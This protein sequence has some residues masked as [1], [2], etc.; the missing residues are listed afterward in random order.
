[1]SWFR[2][3]GW[4]RTP[5]M[6][7][8]LCFIAW[9]HLVDSASV[10]KVWQGVTEKLWSVYALKSP[11]KSGFCLSVEISTIPICRQAIKGS[12]KTRL[13]V[14]IPAQIPR[15]GL[16]NVLTQLNLQSCFRVAWSFSAVPERTTL[17]QVSKSAGAISEKCL[18][19]HF[20]NNWMAEA[21]GNTNSLNANESFFQFMSTTRII[22]QSTVPA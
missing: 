5:K 2:T 19:P 7:F 13:I 20:S 17:L 1:M 16:P 21:M 10:S 18:T 4:N 12:P 8:C 22:S 6:F 9:M 15:R 14:C 11:W 3:S